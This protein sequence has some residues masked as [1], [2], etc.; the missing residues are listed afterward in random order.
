MSEIDKAS[1]QKAELGQDMCR[2]VAKI[3]ATVAL[4][5]TGYIIFLFIQ[6]WS[7]KDVRAIFEI[8]GASVFFISN[9]KRDVVEF[10]VKAM[11][12]A[13]GV[14]A[15]CGIDGIGKINGIFKTSA[16]GAI[17]RNAMMCSAFVFG[18]RAFMTFHDVFN[19]PFFFIFVLWGVSSLLVDFRELFLVEKKSVK[20]TT[21]S[22]LR[23]TSEPSLSEA[24]PEPPKTIVGDV[25]PYYAPDGVLRGYTFEGIVHATQELAEDAKRDKEARIVDGVL[26]ATKEQA[27]EERARRAEIAD[28][29]VD[30]VLYATKEQADAIRAERAEAA[31]CTVDGV[32]YATREQA[33][34]VRA[35]QRAAR[36]VGGVEYATIEEAEQVRQ[37]DKERRTVD[38]VEYATL[39]QAE[40]I[41][42]EMKAAAREARAAKIREAARAVEEKLYDAHDNHMIADALTSTESQ[43]L[44]RDFSQRVDNWL[45]LVDA[46][47]LNKTKIEV[48]K[49]IDEQSAPQPLAKYF[50]RKIDNRLSELELAAQTS[51]ETAQPQTPTLPKPS[52]RPQKQKKSNSGLLLFCAVAVLAGCGWLF[53][54][55]QNN[56]GPF[57]PRAPYQTPPVTR[58]APIVNNI[59]VKQGK[60]DAEIRG[61]KKDPANAKAE[62][63][64]ADVWNVVRA[65]FETSDPARYQTLVRE[66]ENWKKN[67]NGKD[68]I[69]ARAAHLLEQCF[70]G[71]PLRKER[72][73]W[74]GEGAEQDLDVE[75][76]GAFGDKSIIKA[77]LGVEMNDHFGALTAWGLL[78]SDGVGFVGCSESG[79]GDQVASMTLKI[80]G[81]NATVE[82]I[83]GGEAYCGAKA[84]FFE[85][86]PMRIDRRDTL[87]PQAPNV[88]K[89][90]GDRPLTRSD[91]R[92]GY[93]TALGLN[94]RADHDNTSAIVAQAE[95]GASLSI[96]D[97]WQDGESEY[98]WYKIDDLPDKYGWVYGK[99]VTVNGDLQVGIVTL[100]SGKMN[101]HADHTKASENI[102][103]VDAGGRYQV[104]EIWTSNEVPYPWYR[105]VDGSGFTGWVAGRYFKIEGRAANEG[106]K[107][108]DDEYN[109]FRQHIDFVAAE[110]AM[111][112]VWEALRQRASRSR[113]E[114]LLKG[115][116]AWIARRRDRMATDIFNKAGREGL[117]KRECYVR[118]T[119]QRIKELQ[120]ALSK[121]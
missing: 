110:D 20:T 60:E 61:T 81:Q 3:I 114:E 90:T 95:Q 69:I 24:M 87:Q 45:A 28:R 52:S 67:A 66:Q 7:K 48:Q 59:Q 112:I 77:E 68:K 34:A 104:A 55:K 91:A 89:L 106:Y 121:L 37:T 86:T 31:A 109:E 115:Q 57:A 16:K 13:L 73:V 117:S 46:N 43:N 25:T 105:L 72:F 18:A 39:E 49:Y 83:E 8:F 102:G 51:Q 4:I 33:E 98:P 22:V 82:D 75:W 30:G 29:T 92:K 119:Q 41:R 80:Q 23:T 71:N 100:K 40:Q 111:G 103:T 107:L 53:W 27:D 10:I 21:P 12:F 15:L 44:R 38:G 63:M 65:R 78:N 70:N 76:F 11:P 42:A 2:M 79:L 58:N 56:K 116:K 1:N 93:V 36:T 17:F 96:V 113:Y 62:K 26:Y 47:I 118:A 120:A 94:V 9:D 101:I 84:G 64:L 85:N 14:V 97:S 108:S 5:Y 99:Y 19:N 50:L 54:A 6:A 88:P 74:T 35:E 32:R